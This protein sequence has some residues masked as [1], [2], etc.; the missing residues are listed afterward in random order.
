M[1]FQ[2]AACGKRFGGL[3]GFERHRV[4]RMVDVPPHYGRR[5]LDA[6]A[7][8]ERGYR[9][10]ARGEWVIPLPA[11]KCLWRATQGVLEASAPVGETKP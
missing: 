9:P 6:A 11:G 1:S 5:C 7:L 2:C 8:R 4:G 3:I 10:N